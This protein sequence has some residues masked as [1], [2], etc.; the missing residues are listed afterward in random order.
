MGSSPFATCTVANE[1]PTRTVNIGYDFQLGK[2]EVTQAQWYAVKLGF[3]VFQP[4]TN[5][6]LPV[7]SVSWNDIASFIEDLN[8]LG[9]GTFRLPTEAEWE[10]A[11][12]AGSNT[13]WFHGDTEEGLEDYAWYS[14]N[15]TA[16]GWKVVG[17]KLPNAFGLYDM[18]GNVWEWVQDWYHPT[19]EGAPND[20]SAWEDPAGT[21]RVQRGGFY[22]TTES[23]CRSAFRTLDSPTAR[24][25][26]SGFRLVRTN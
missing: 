1:Q 16:S 9:I 26:Y 3:P 19:Y 12:R 2:F 11:C 21:G 22:N 14:R 13:C 10:Y 5:P 23:G 7:V 25:P 4:T 18:H 6:D 8:E 15:Y 24:D 17:Q 20:G